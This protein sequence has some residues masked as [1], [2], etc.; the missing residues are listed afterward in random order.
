MVTILIQHICKLAES[1]WDIPALKAR[2]ETAVR[3][4]ND[5]IRGGK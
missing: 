2:K 5:S 4:G 1:M 3:C